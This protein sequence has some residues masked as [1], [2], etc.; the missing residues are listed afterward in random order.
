M[1][2]K[3]SNKEKGNKFENIC[4]NT[5]NS[6]A[7]VFD[8]GDLKTS[9]LVIE[10]KFTEGKGFRITTKILEKIW[11]EALDSGKLP[12]LL[13]GIK[14]GTILWTLSCDITKGVI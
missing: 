3:K 8:K 4:K 13:I 6:G 10:A 12:R 5:I 9:E 1:A 14:E 7:L 2:K 11:G